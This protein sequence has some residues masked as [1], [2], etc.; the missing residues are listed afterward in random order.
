MGDALRL[1]LPLS[2]EPSFIKLLAR[3]SAIETALRLEASCLF[4]FVARG[5]LNVA[6]ETAQARLG[7]NEALLLYR[8]EAC[9]IGLRTELGAQAYVVAFRTLVSREDPRSRTLA[10]PVHAMVANPERL[11]DLLRMLV[12]EQERQS[13]SL[14]IL[15]NLLVL[16]LNE[17]DASAT[18]QK[19]LRVK[20]PEPENLASL[21]DAYIAAHYSEAVSS[22]DIARYLNYSVEYINR[23]FHR[24]RGMSVRDAIHCRRIKEASALLDSRRDLPISDIATMCGY[25]DVGYF[26]RIFKRLARTTPCKLRKGLAST[27]SGEDM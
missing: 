2:L 10:V 14:P 11:A 5:W 18:G 27:G 21:V 16:V 9:A 20:T 6:E 23:V 3:D 25:K 12:G 13:P 1:T 7:P 22:V 8:H 24:K 26:R 17:F 15:S 4:I 19:S